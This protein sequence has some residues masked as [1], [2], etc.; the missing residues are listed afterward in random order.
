MNI[1]SII[2]P[3]LLSSPDLTILEMTEMV[4]M[5]LRHNIYMKSIVLVLL[6][7]VHMM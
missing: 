1:V 2:S 5:Y 6:R 7:K 4:K 3:D